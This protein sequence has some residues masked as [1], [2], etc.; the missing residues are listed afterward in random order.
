M[1]RFID[2]LSRVSNSCSDATLRLTSFL[3]V[4]GEEAIPHERTPR[5]GTNLSDSPYVP[6]GG[7]KSR[8]KI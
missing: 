7:L 1:R 2:I 3:R 4:P 6:W 5:A 8:R